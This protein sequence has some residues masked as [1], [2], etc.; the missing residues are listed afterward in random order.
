MKKKI[1]YIIGQLSVGGS[2]RYVLS[3]AEHID[4]NQYRPTIICLSKTLELHDELSKIDCDLHVFNYSIL[5]KIRTILALRTKLKHL[6][7]DIVHTI[8]RSWYYTIPACYLSGIQNIIISSRSIPP[9]KKWYH[10]MADK[11]LFKKVKLAMF[12]SDQ[13]RQS[14]W[15]D[16]GLPINKSLV[17]H[18]AVDLD[19]FDKNQ[20]AKTQNPINISSIQNRPEPIICIVA[21]LTPTK[22]IDTAILAQKLLV[23]SYPDAQLLII[24]TGRSEQKLKNL[25]SK[26]N[27]EKNVQFLGRRK[28]I[29]SILKISDI[30]LLTSISEGSS[31]SLLEYMAARL[32]IIAT[33]VG[34]TPEIIDD[35]TGILIPPKS[36]KTLHESIIKLLKNPQLSSTLGIN[37]RKKVETKFTLNQMIKDT[38]KGY[39]SVS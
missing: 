5:S 33:K 15:L 24:G 18:S 3:L 31:N 30:G 25:V 17:I 13:V 14:T 38:V 7:P 26:L 29:P 21:N 39:R 22:S 4:K 2:E 12:N 34:G 27:I 6:K 32:P 28:D 11:L 19:V 1:A 8:G 16:L 20:T 35:Q 23:E 10:R 37:A 9:W 36:P